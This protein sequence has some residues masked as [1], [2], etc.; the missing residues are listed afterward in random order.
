MNSIPLVKK[1]A[2]IGTNS[3]VLCGVT[4]GR[5]AMVGGGSVVTKDVPD[6]GLV[7]GSPARLR[8]FVC[9]CGESLK[10]AG[11]D[12]DSVV[13]KCEGCG[14]SSGIPKEIHAAAVR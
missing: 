13:M 11:R 7:Y 9:E 8:G 6:H 10:E 5:F 1:G 2:S 4:I 14:G 12:G 3:T